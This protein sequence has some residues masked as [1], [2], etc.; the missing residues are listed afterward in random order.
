MLSNQEKRALKA[1][2]HSLHPVVMTGAKGLT[3]SVIE[4]IDVNLTAHELIKIKLVADD[5]PHRL[6]M[7][8]EILQKTGAELIQTIGHTATIYRQKPED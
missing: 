2:A 3:E 7:I 8:E 4:E 5:K 6:S 1:K